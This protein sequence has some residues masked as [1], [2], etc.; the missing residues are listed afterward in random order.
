MIASEFRIT[1]PFYRAINKM[2]LE[3]AKINIKH[4]TNNVNTNDT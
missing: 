4:I 1:K 2:N 3:I